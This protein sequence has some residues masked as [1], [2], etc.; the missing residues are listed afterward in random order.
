MSSSRA[1]LCRWAPFMSSRWSSATDSGRPVRA[2]QQIIGV[3]NRVGTTC[4]NTVHNIPIGNSKT[5]HVV[6]SGTCLRAETALISAVT[7]MSWAPISA[8]PGRTASASVDA[9]PA[10]NLIHSP[11]PGAPPD[12]ALRARVDSSAT[13]PPYPGRASASAGE[14]VPANGRHE[15]AMLSCLDSSRTLRRRLNRL[16]CRRLT[17]ADR[18]SP[19][20][21]RDRRIVTLSLGN[22]RSHSNN[23]LAIRSPD[24]YVERH[25]STA[26]QY[27]VRAYLDFSRNHPRASRPLG[28]A[29]QLAQT[30]Q[31]D[32]YRSALFNCGH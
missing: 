13:A 4:A 25:A 11:G 7:L 30:D 32:F 19:R 14:P 3:N 21:M 2:H 18:Q 23:R 16:R 22:A 12:R 29:W 28:R 8:N 17:A 10:I 1:A 9:S 15:S 20:S 31:Y 6:W 5:C 26:C 27:R 24:E